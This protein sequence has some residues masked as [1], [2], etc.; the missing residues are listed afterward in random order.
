MDF[1]AP[2]ADQVLAIRINAGIDELA[3]HAR[4]AAATPDMVEAIVDGIGQFAAGEFAPLNRKGDVEGA[5][6]ADGEV[7]LPD[8]FAEA[9]RAYVEQG[10]NA[11][12][13]DAQFGGQGL[14]FAL[15]A[16]VLENLGAAN[17]AFSLLPMLTVGAIEALA[18]HGS[19]NQK[20][21]YLARLISGEWS[22][23]M[24]L[25]EPQ[26]GSDVGALRTTATPRGDGT[27]LIKGTKIF[28]T[29]GEHQL[30]GNIVH[31][32]L[33]RTPGAPAGSRGISLF[34]V[35]KYLVNPDG[36]HGARNDLRCVSLEH[37][38]G[39]MASPTCVMS[40]GD[41]D[42]CIGELVGHENEGLK[43]MFTMMNSA[44]INV[45]S[46]GVQIAER[47]LQQASG[48]AR[49]RVQSARAGSPDKA[50]VA[51]VEHPDV[52]RM[53]LR[54]RALTEGARA[55]LYYTAGQV[56]RGAL[57]I[58]GAQQRAD[59][60]VPLI[61][62]WGTD[63]GCEVASIGVQIHGGM[64]FIEETGAA[65]HY[66]DSRIAPI[67][68]G[69]NGIQAA[70]LVTRKLGYEGG[71]VLKALLADRARDAAAYPDLAALAQDCAAIADWMTTSASLDD[72]LAGSVA[73]CTMCAVA[74]AGAQLARQAKALAGDDTP[75]ARAKAVVARYFAEVIATE[76]RGLKAAAMAGAGLLYELD[77]ENLAG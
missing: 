54:M 23:T 31:L 10:W 28:I 3:G 49:E 56:D 47:A 13:G 55:L 42:A 35:P 60:L 46:Q 39:I 76:A 34:V 38:L 44:R 9:Y 58:A 11:I 8:G 45:G 51:I 15:A 59:C 32:V 1:T 6:L 50:P 61:K 22:G 41:N 69:T 71:K 64:G 33:A 62:A 52:R 2:T 65:Q 68:E 63:V 57:G 77:S 67:Y 4:F 19:D 48:Y 29:W 12:S 73:F 70:D 72:R 25:T 27:W 37:K 26:A 14:P 66:R 40:F 16:N 36:T 43:A 7:A 53:L 74:V 30:A 5:R 20:A 17:M 24:N 18:H 75:Q 21:T